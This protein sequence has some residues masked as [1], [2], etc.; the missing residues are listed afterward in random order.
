MTEIVLSERTAT[1]SPSMPVTAQRPG[2]ALAVLAAAT[3][4]VVLDASIATIALPHAQADLGIGEAARHWVLTAYALPFGALLLLGGRVADLF[5]RKRAFLIGLGAFALASAVAG[6]A[7]GAGVLF[8]ARA[9]QGAAAAVLA[10]AALSLLS[11]TFVEPTER[12]R[13]FGVYGAVQGSGGALGVLLGGVLTEY[14]SWRW[15]MLIAAPV[16]I[17]ALIAAGSVLPESRLAGPRR[18]D[19]P[20]AVLVTV[21]LTCA[22]YG[23]TLAADV[24]HGWSAPAT[25]T[26]FAL[27]G[28]L[29]VGFVAV[30]RR[31]TIPLLPFRLLGDRTRAGVLVTS[32]LVGAA[33]FGTLL[34]LTLYFQ[35]GKGFGA[36]AT[37]FAFLPFAVGIVVM[38]SSMGR[39]LPRFGQRRLMLT[40]LAAAT[41]AGLWLSR[42]DPSASWLVAVLPAEILMSAGLGLVFVPLFT[43]GLHGAG[44]QDAGVV[45]GA[46]DATQQVGGALGVALLNAVFVAQASTGQ[47]STL[48]ADIDGYRLAL[49]VATG[50][51]AAALAVVAATVGRDGGGQEP[52]R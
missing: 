12:A 29:L 45:S 37:G 21:G 10:P 15:C 8:G 11:V 22:V 50:L 25:L 36:L 39:L 4:L 48:A 26:Q 24:R 19:V 30:E 27:A 44:E 7:P 32:V 33:M 1:A 38:A 28:A 3:L 31:A 43:A 17:A 20:G 13:A 51:F 2:R 40:G 5:G 23:F 35:V 14:A 47:A 16:A 52:I 34:F 41:L 49:A 9:A 18:L 42:L 6:A 46:L